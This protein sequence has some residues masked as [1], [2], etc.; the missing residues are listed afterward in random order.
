MDLATPEKKNKTIMI[1]DNLET[2]ILGANNFGIHSLLIASG[3]HKLVH[4]NKGGVLKGELNELQKN[5]KVDANY[6]MPSLRW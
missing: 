4:P 2:D 6:V 3:V 5:F 1:G